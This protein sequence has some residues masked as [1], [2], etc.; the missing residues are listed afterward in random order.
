ML[1]GRDAERDSLAALLDGAREARAG[2]L[3]LHGE[4]G[5]GKTALLDDAVGTAAGLRVLRTQG[6]ESE[7]PL[8]FAA[9]HRL[10]RPL[11][12]HLDRLPAPQA[13]AL[14]VAFGKQDGERVDPLLVGIGTLSLLT[15][16]AEQRPVLAVVDDAHW[17][18]PASAD[19][20]LFTARR[21]GADRVV[22]LFSVRDGSATAFAHDGVPSLLV[23][24]LDEVSARAVLQ[25]CAGD[26]IA[27][28]VADR[29]LEQS[30]GNP[31]ALVELA[32]GLSPAQLAGDAPTPAHLPLT[33][34]LE[35]VFLDRAR[36][37][38]TQVQSVVL[39]AAADDSGRTSTVSRAA[40]LL[41]LDDGALAQAETSGLVVT[42]G[43]HLHVRHPLVRSAI[44]QAA[45]GGERRAAHRALAA[46][47]EGQDDPDR[48]AWHAAAA[49]DGPDETLAAALDAAGARA[50]RRGGFV[51]AC[52]A[53]E[54][55]AELT[56]GA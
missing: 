31:L 18:D 34:D 13:R 10:L 42:D 3:V 24:R 35:R 47:L 30:G 36:R 45:T 16:A 14:G 23:G 41:G 53:Y 43:D 9:L 15:E 19:A 8:A 52:D 20:L 48:Q 25:D 33:A 38:P 54:R 17:L 1:H 37:L 46:A 28:D 44:Y 32:A 5:V 21:L 29:L 7:S 49:A 6:L 26:A 27:L 55:A 12:P 4:P 56:A 40:A 50:E 39:V 51:A 22:L 11:L 2:A